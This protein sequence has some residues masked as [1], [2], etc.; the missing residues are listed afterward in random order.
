MKSSDAGEKQWYFQNPLKEKLTRGRKSLI[1]LRRF[2]G[3]ESNEN[4]KVREKKRTTSEGI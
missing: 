3:N 2:Y 4:F 1:I